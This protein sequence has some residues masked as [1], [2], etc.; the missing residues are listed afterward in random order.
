MIRIEMKRAVT[1]PSLDHLTRLLHL[2]SYHRT[3]LPDYQS[4]LIGAALPTSFI[5]LD[6]N[7]DRSAPLYSDSIKNFFN[8]QYSVELAVGNPKDKFTFIIDTGSGTT[9]LNEKR[10]QTF[11]CK[12][13]KAFDSKKSQH[14]SPFGKLIRINYAKGGVTIELAKDYFYFQDLRIT[15]QEFGVILKEDGLF[16][17]A[18]YDG[19]IGFSYPALSDNTKPFFDRIIEMRTLPKNIFSMYLSRDPKVKS[20]LFLGGYDE[21]LIEG[22]INYHPVVKKTW[23]TLNLDRVLINGQDSLLCTSSTKC[24]IIMDTGSSLMA[25]PPWA[26]NSLLSQISKYSDCRNILAFPSITFI[27][28]S[29]PYTIDAYEYVLTSMNTIKYDPAPNASANLGEG[30]CTFGFSIFDVGKDNVWIAGDIFLTKYFT[31]YD[32]DNDRVGIALAKQMK[33]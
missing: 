6:L 4:P 29:Q 8:T 15:N 18:S 31:I 24:K 32:R 23:W 33:G 9:L 13:R 25:S 2:D 20:E 27:I 16:Q 3:V 28:D 7:L 11:G 5:Q 10:C 19:I 21:K 12:T 1:S 14:Y 30:D 22:P 17:A 26:L